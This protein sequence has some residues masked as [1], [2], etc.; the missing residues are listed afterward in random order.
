MLYS[1]NTFVFIF[2]LQLIL[3]FQNLEAEGISYIKSI[4]LLY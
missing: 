4:L 1:K 3:A 2:D